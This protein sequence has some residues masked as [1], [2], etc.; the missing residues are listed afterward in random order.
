MRGAFA[1][2]VDLS[3]A[4]VAVVDDVLTSG[5]TLSELART[6]RRAGAAEVIGWIVAR[7]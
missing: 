3:G 5:A 2:E 6:L 7:T 4:R 1:C